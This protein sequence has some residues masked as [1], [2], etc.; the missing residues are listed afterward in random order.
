VTL[1]KHPAFRERIAKAY[2]DLEVMRSIGYRLVTSIMRHGRPGTEGS[3][4]KLYWSEMVRRMNL[5]A[6]QMEGEAGMLDG[7]DSELDGKWQRGFLSSFAQTIAAGSTEIQKNIISE[8][9][10]GM[11]RGE[12]WQPREKKAV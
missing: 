10:L 6:L 7:E 1:S 2:A 9:V 5:L 4:A 12:V 8:R 11:P 3:I